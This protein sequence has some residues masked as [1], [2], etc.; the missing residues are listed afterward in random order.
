MNLIILLYP[1]SIIVIVIFYVVLYM[2]FHNIYGIILCLLSITKWISI[3]PIITWMNN[4]IYEWCKDDFDRIKYN[5]RET[6]LVKGNITNT[7]QAIYVLHPHGLFSLTHAFHI[8]TDITNWP[9]RN[10]YSII[11]HLFDNLIPFS[12]DFMNDRER[13]ITSKY[14]Y[15]KDALQ[16]RKSISVCLGN[17]T[18]GQYDDEHRITAIVKKRKGIFK[19]AIET[20]VPIIPVLSYGEQSIFKKI[21]KCGISDLI[22]MLLGMRLS[23]P[24]VSSIVEWLTIYKK[25]LDKKVVT[26]IGDPIEVGEAR[27]PT[28][29][30]I[31]ELRN[32][33]MDALR[34]LYKDTKPV[35]YED[36]IVFV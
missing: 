36:E 35:D 21:N 11:S 13:M 1:V 4:I 23:F 29:M 16:E 27:T 15:M 19:M 25:P 7:Q 10:V 3:K 2:C 33:Y 31:D 32:K 34:K 30:E 14:S 12:L 18:E 24:N 17:Y 6:F 22:Y 9:Y 28:S 26:Y 20:G 5:I 8:N